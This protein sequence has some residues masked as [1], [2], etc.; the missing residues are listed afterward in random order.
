MD[1]FTMYFLPELT[2]SQIRQVLESAGFEARS[3]GPGKVS[4]SR[5]EGQIW[6]YLSKR[7]ELEPSDFEDENEWPIQRDSLGTLA[8][9]VVRRNSESEELAVRI[10]NQLATR[11]AGRITWDGMNHWEQLYN[12][13]VAQHGHQE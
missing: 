7:H 4:V 12:T 10:A 2:D 5:G 9:L 8:S 13:Y 11:Y 1:G 6:I 3:Q